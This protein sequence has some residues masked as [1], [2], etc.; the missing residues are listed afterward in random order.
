MDSI[1]NIELLILDQRKN[2]NALNVASYHRRKFEGTN[3]LIIPLELQKKRARKIKKI[4]VQDIINY[5]PT[6]KRGRP[7]RIKYN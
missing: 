2:K 5:I 4:D 6:K 7:K 3:K 1:Q